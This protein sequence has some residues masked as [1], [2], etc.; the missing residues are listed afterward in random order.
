MLKWTVINMDIHTATEQAYKK[1]YEDGKRDSVS[2]GV[3][4]QV[5]WERDIAIEQLK[6]IGLGLGEK[7]DCVKKI[8]Y[9]ENCSFYE[10]GFCFSRHVGCGTV[11]PPRKPDDFCSYGK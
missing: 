2:R 7:T 1:G 5:L 4:E 9:C 3:Y 11:T 10:N 8:T 6:S